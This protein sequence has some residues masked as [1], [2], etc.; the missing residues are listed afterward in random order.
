MR[1]VL[2]V[3]LLTPYSHNC[4]RGFYQAW[5]AVALSV[6]LLRQVGAHFTQQQKRSDDSDLLLRIRVS[7]R[8]TALPFAGYSPSRRGRHALLRSG[9]AA[10]AI[11]GGGS[12]A[13]TG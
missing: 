2:L 6:S 7:G 5:P 10:P 11:R 3:R 13:P 1:L 9:V 4:S 12:R 8:L